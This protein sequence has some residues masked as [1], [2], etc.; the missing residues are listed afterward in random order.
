ML[1]WKVTRQH[2]LI[3]QAGTRNPDGT[4]SFLP[5]RVF[6]Q[7]LSG[8]FLWWLIGV[9]WVAFAVFFHFFAPDPTKVEELSLALYFFYALG[10]FFMLI[11]ILSYLVGFRKRTTFSIEGSEFVITGRK[12]SNHKEKYPAALLK[13]MQLEVRPVVIRGIRR[14]EETVF[15]KENY[16]VFWVWFVIVILDRENDKLLPPF[17]SFRI[18]AQEHKPRTGHIPPDVVTVTTWFRDTLSIDVAYVKMGNLDED[19]RT[20]KGWDSI[21]L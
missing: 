13:T 14:H 6:S 19:P 15:K 9:P 5:T 2:D 10:G 1:E 12:W 16:P 11:G 7:G 21:G 20:P 18:I 8:M 3:G 4:I 17:L